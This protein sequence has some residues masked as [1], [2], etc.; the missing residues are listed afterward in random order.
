MKTLALVT[1]ATCALSALAMTGCVAASDPG[2][3]GTDPDQSAASVDPPAEA[4]GVSWTREVSARRAAERGRKV[5]NMTY[6]GG[7]IMKT[8]VTKNIFWGTS[9]AGYSG[10]KQTGL[11][12]WYTGYSNSHYSG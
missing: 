3:D 1:C 7:K 2:E 9:W 5:G 4:R 6:H 10:D 12:T 8:A 11:D